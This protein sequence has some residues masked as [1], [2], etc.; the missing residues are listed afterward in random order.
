MISPSRGENKKYLKPPPSQQP[1]Q[2]TFPRTCLKTPRSAPQQEK[3]SAS[4]GRFFWRQPGSGRMMLH[5]P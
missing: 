3:A 5:G 4:E 2:P 1:Q